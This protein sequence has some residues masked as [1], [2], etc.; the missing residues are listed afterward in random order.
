MGQVGLHPRRTSSERERVA[1][2][3]GP[4]DDPGR[5]IS[6][7]RELGDQEGDPPPSLTAVKGTRQ[8]WPRA[9]R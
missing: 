6:G 4:D 2:F 8:P 7:R 9:K 1:A 3:H 5:R